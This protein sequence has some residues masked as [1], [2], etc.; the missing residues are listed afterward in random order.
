MYELP[1]A[2][3]SLDEAGDAVAAESEQK[4][5]AALNAAAKRQHQPNSGKAKPLPLDEISLLSDAGG[6]A[7]GSEEAAAAAE[8]RFYLPYTGNG[9]IGL[10][11]L[12]R[13]GGS[14]A[15]QGLHATYHKTLSLPLMYN[16]LALVY[17]DGQLPRK[18]VVFVE[19]ASGLVNRLSCYQIV[20]SNLIEALSTQNLSNFDYFFFVRLF[21]IKTAF[22]C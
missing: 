8:D 6:S 7:S 16:P 4:R 18:E 2:S 9:Y 20:N 5:V 1:F 15:A 13:A 22:R 17:G 14:T 19:L 10:G 11:L 3:Q 12:N 21:R